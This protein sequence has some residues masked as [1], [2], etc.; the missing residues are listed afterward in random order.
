ML[1]VVAPRQISFT[2]FCAANV[3]MDTEPGY[4]MLTGQYPLHRFAHTYV[5]ATLVGG[6]TIALLLTS[7]A[8]AKKWRLPNWFGWLGLTTKAIVLGSLTGTYSHVFLDSL[9][10]VDI[11]PFAPFSDANP[12]LLVIP[13]ETLHHACLFAGILALGIA[14]FR[15]WKVWLDSTI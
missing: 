12:M 8:L 1:H 2:A 11:R 10:H 15:W 13:V 6:G 4:Y 14:V 7:M 3:L 5:G 9:M